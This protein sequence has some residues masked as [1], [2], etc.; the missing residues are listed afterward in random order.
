MLRE[1]QRQRARLNGYWHLLQGDMRLLPIKGGWAEVCLAGWAIG[2]MTSWFYEDWQRQIGSVIAEM[3]RV[4]IP[5]GTIIIM[6]TLT[7]G[8][9]KPAP[10][11]QG[12]ADFY[13]WLE[14]QHGFVRSVIQTDYL[15][16]NVEDAV[17]NTEFF[18]GAE[19]AQTIRQRS[20]ARLPEWTGIWSKHNTL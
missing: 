15:F 14:N 6:E 10:P 7:T 18:F 13:A 2:H 1:Q 16:K 5:T 20:W 12:L 11:T 3:Q 9:E 19:L 8:A 17:Q 4:T